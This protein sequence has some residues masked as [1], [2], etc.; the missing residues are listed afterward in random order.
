MKIILINLCN[1]NFLCVGN[2]IIPMVTILLNSVPWLE[3]L[4]KVVGWKRHYMIRFFKS[5]FFFIPNA[6][7]NDFVIINIKA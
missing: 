5:S 7:L 4:I 3:S 2:M 1:N 6:F